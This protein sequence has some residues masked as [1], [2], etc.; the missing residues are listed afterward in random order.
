MTIQANFTTAALNERYTVLFNPFAIHTH[1]S[2]GSRQRDYKAMNN[3]LTPDFQNAAQSMNIEIIPS[4]FSRVSPS[5]HLN[6]IFILIYH[7]QYT[8]LVH[9]RSSR[10]LPQGK[11]VFPSGGGYDR[12]DISR[13][14]L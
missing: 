3:L 4:N 5:H 13:C 10:T 8:I 11:N 9:M 12:E 14:S 6:F 1:S 7:G 2:T